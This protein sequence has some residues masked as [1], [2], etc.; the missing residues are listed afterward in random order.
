MKQIIYIFILLCTLFQTRIFAQSVKDSTVRILMV[1]MHFSGQLPKYDLE[2]RFGANFSVGSSF[3]WKTKHNLLFSAEGSYFFGSN[4]ADKQVELVG[5]KKIWWND[6]RIVH[7]S[8]YLLFSY[9]AFNQNKDAWLILLIDT[10]I[11]L[12]SWT[13]YHKLILGLSPNIKLITSNQLI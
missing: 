6:L 8:L 1:G 12:V 3:I 5:E 10:L 7:G 9:M 2:K 13:K 11:G 4:V